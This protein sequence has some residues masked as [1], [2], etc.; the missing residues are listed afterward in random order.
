MYINW[1]TWIIFIRDYI[2]YTK[3]W[4]QQELSRFSQRNGKL[5]L[6]RRKQGNYPVIPIY[7]NVEH[8]QCSTRTY[9]QIISEHMY[10]Y[11]ITNL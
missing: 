10:V 11:Y 3:N 4:G 1:S 2:C 7:V 6:P 8:L 5:P 9:L